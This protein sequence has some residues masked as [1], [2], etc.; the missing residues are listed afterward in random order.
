MR[1]KSLPP[2]PKTAIEALVEGPRAHTVSRK[3][4]FLLHHDPDMI[5][6]ATN[7]GLEYLLR[8]NYMIG[9]GTFKSAPTPFEQIHTLFGQCG[10]W[11]KLVVW[12]ML[13]AKERLFTNVFFFRTKLY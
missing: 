11:K 8:A 5:I 13:L 4:R 10:D 1:S 9:H 7:Q 3:Q 6:F 12:A 2:T